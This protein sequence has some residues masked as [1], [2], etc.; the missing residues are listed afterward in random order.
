MKGKEANLAAIQKM[1][2]LDNTI[3]AV[4]AG[5][6]TSIMTNPIWVVKT[7][8]Q[9]QFYGHENKYRGLVRNYF[10]YFYFVGFK[11]FK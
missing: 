2:P 3:C 5:W 11:F 1:G 4:L 10:Y 9:I 7:R 8:M 6:T